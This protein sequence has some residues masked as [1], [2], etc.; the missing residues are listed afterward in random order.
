M[1][2][3]NKKL[4]FFIILWIALSI[5]SFFLLYSTYSAIR[6]VSIFFVIVWMGIS[7]GLLIYFYECLSRRHMKKHNPELYKIYMKYVE[8]K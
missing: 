6:L 4:L 1:K 7:Y 3:I 2:L 8:K 5:L